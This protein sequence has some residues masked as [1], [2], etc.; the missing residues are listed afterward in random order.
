MNKNREGLT[1]AN[2]RK[3]EG[4]DRMVVMIDPEVIRLAK[5]LAAQKGLSL[6]M[7]VELALKQYLKGGVK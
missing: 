3:S 4:R 1:M 2:Q 5:S 7:I 6:W